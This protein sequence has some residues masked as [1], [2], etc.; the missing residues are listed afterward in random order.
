MIN[1][2]LRQEDKSVIFRLNH[3]N[4]V[5]YC[6]V[7]N[8]DKA[9]VSAFRF[10]TKCVF[11]YCVIFLLLSGL[12]GLTVPSERTHSACSHTTYCMYFDILF[13]ISYN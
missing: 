2:E 5:M 3:D 6:S 13:Y 12:N 1:T 4:V 11:I 7:L 9:I 8:D 10:G